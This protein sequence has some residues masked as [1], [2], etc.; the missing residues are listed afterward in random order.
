MWTYPSLVPRLSP[1]IDEKI[2]KEGESLVLIR[3]RYR[4]TTPLHQPLN[5]LKRHS[6]EDHEVA[7]K[8][9]QLRILLLQ[10]VMLECLLLCSYVGA[11]KC[12]CDFI[13]YARV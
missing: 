2:E 7:T 4:S 8:Y 3:M 5:N 10:L 6:R 1:H 11:L 9:S 12:G 13:L